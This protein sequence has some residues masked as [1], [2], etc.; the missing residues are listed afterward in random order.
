MKPIIKVFLLSIA[1]LIAFGQ[2]KKVFILEIKSEIDPRMSRYVD[3]ALK[4]ATDQ[5][6]DYILI[7]MDTFGGALDDADKIRTAILNYPKPVLVFINKNAASAGALISIACDS[8]YMAQGSSIGAATVVNGSDGLAAPD[9]YQ[10]YMRSIMR[11]TAETNHRDPKIAEAM[12]DQDIILDSTIKRDGKVLT[13]TTSEAIKYNFCEASVSNNVEILKLN[14]ISDASVIRY[15]PSMT[16]KIISLFL[17]PAVSS[18]LILIMIGGIWFE[19]QSPGIGFALLAAVLAAVLYF[20][21]YYLNGLAEN[22][23]ILIFVVGVILLG[24]EIFVIPGFGLT[25]VSGIICIFAS[26]I[27]SM[28]NNDYFN[29]E[30]VKSADIFTSLLIVLSSFILTIGLLFFAGSRILESRM[31]KRVALQDTHIQP[32]KK[33]TQYTGLIGT[34][35]TVLRPSGKVQLETGVFDA[36]TAGEYIEKDEQIIVLGEINGS[37]K[38]KKA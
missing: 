32:I 10:S 24:L 17:N 3:L 5:N 30:F 19:L 12:V 1:T 16:E 33:E 23:E 27:L 25:G 15:E 21:P 22:W 18:I 4:D 36:F 8:I 20:T 6:A 11:A 13:F 2:T 31:L 37:L 34:A 35:Q 29:F 26:L 38:V 28:L 9:K 14:N 7:E